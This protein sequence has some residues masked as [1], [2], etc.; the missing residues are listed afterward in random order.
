MRFYTPSLKN[1]FPKVFKTP[2]KKEPSTPFP[3]PSK[4]SSVNGHEGHT[5]EIQMSTDSIRKYAEPICNPT[6]KSLTPSSRN[7]ELPEFLRSPPNMPGGNLPENNN[8]LKQ[9]SKNPH[10]E[11]RLKEL[12]A[13][14]NIEISNE[15]A[16]MRGELENWTKSAPTEIEKKGRVHSSDK[17]LDAHINLLPELDLRSQHLTSMPDC[18]GKLIFL[19]HLNLSGNPLVEFPSRQIIQL[20]GL[21][22]IQLSMNESGG[23]PI[24]RS[25]EVLHDLG[26]KTVNFPQG[27]SR[28]KVLHALPDNDTALYT[29]DLGPCLAVMIMQE[30]KVLCAHVDS[31]SGGGLGGL[32]THELLSRHI[33]PNTVNSKIFLVG[34][35]EQGSAA[36]LRG[37]LISFQKLG[38]VECVK[39]ASLG[40]GNTSTTLDLK[41]KMAYVGRG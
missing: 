27:N 30:N 10:S 31:Y 29:T 35:N 17:I 3:H 7:E 32:S 2:L 28:A 22:T 40:E 19:K 23:T 20:K 26:Y 25:H 39:M 5:Q 21:Q 15:H 41:N 1:P 11:T 6:Q 16:K 33:K 18:L 36:N 24:R 12:E 4:T 14:Q 37:V 13:P 9:V 38:I 8:L 34:A